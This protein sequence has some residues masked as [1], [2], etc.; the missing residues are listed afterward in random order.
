M[1][2]K[3][4]SPSGSAAP[5]SPKEGRTGAARM[6]TDDES[7][8]QGVPDDGSDERRRALF[9]LEAMRKR[10]LIPEAEYERRKQALKS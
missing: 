4:D 8:T 2:A 9:A 5:I 3:K 6:E 1:S 7:G 10:G